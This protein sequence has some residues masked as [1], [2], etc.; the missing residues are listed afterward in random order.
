ME[1]LMWDGKAGT[2]EDQSI[3]PFLA[4]TELDLSPEEAVEKLRRQGYSDEF[5]RVFGEDVT[6]ANLAKALAAYQRTLIAGS[7]PFDEFVFRGDTSAIEDAAQRGFAV[8]LRAKCDACHLIM[9]PGFHPFAVQHVMFT[10]GAFHNLG[11][12]ASKTN[13]DPGRYA[14]TG[15]AADWGRFRTPTLR[16]V[17]L[18]APYFHDGSAA[19]LLDVVEFYDRGGGQNRNLDPAMQPLHLLPEEKKDLVAF[20]RSLTSAGATALAQ[21]SDSLE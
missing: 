3:L 19:T 21:E 18:T 6:I 16:N 14:V 7:S 13:P 8:F 17:A 10:D 9:A 1:P 4:P 2:L 15:D 20:L 11:V 5:Q 12:D